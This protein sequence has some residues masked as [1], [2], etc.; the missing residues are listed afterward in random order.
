MWLPGVEVDLEEERLVAIR[1][2]SMEVAVLVASRGIEILAVGEVYRL[3]V[4]GTFVGK[5][6]GKT[7]ADYG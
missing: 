1:Y 3:D 4:A 7:R 2:G 6:S 5:P